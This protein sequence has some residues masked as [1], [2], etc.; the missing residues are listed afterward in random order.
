MVHGTQ[1]VDKYHKA[2]RRL[3]DRNEK[4]SRAMRDSQLLMHASQSQGFPLLLKVHP[5][6]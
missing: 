6:M 1:G 2:G 3:T 4:I 5:I